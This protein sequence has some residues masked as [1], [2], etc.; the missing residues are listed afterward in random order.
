M[1]LIE[2]PP[3]FDLCFLAAGAL[4]AGSSALRR[5]F[6]AP[7]PEFRFPLARVL[8]RAISLSSDP[9]LPSLTPRA[10]LPVSDGAPFIWGDVFIGCTAGAAEMEARVCTCAGGTTGY[11]C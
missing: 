10:E 3:P 1:L 8:G 5:E 11:C 6:A 4:V 2:A 7:P 9:A